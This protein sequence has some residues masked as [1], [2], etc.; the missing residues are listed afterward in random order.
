MLKTFLLFLKLVQLY[1][2]LLNV[3]SYLIAKLFSLHYKGVILFYNFYEINKCKINL[4]IK[5]RV[6]ISNIK[7]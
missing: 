6:S 5:I 4:R 3:S 7:N 2:L 1:T